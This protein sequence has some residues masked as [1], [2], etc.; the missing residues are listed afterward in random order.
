M[1]VFSGYKHPNGLIPMLEIY[2]DPLGLITSMIL[3]LPSLILMILLFSISEQPSIKVLVMKPW[4]SLTSNY[5]SF[6]K[7]MNV[8]TS[9]LMKD[10]VMMKPPMP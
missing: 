5:M 7:M 8:L 9:V 2:A 6:K 3:I 1:E 10:T 4:V